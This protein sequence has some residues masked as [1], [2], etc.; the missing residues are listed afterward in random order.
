[1]FNAANKSI[2]A[3]LIA[4]ALVSCGENNKEKAQALLDEAS[5]LV[6]CGN[7]S[8]AIEVIDTLDCRYAKEIEV[9][10]QGMLYRARAVEGMAKDSI[11]AADDMLTRSLQVHG[12]FIAADN[13]FTHLGRQFDWY[14]ALR[15]AKLIL[16]DGGIGFERFDKRCGFFLRQNDQL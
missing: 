14:R 2:A 3:V 7:Y 10:K 12:I 6:E 9:R 11:I 13:R 1:M 16:V 8:A 5:S 4:A 15:T